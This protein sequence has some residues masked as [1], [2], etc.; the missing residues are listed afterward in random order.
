M[1][2]SRLSHTRRSGL[3]KPGGGVQGHRLV[4]RSLEAPGDTLHVDLW[5][6]GASPG[7]EGAA[8]IWGGSCPPPRDSACLPSRSPPHP[9]PLETETLNQGGVTMAQGPHSATI[10]KL[11]IVFQ[12]RTCIFIL[13]WELG[14]IQRVCIKPG[15]SRLGGLLS[16][17][18]WPQLERG[19]D[20]KGVDRDRPNT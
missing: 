15:G 16:S 18:G 13:H 3:A 6:P 20:W 10:L 1:A 11:V 8:V 5:G 2:V 17:E 7:R 9:H 4:C 12:Q 14:L 19:G